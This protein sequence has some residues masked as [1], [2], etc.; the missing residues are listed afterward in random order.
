MHVRP[1]PEIDPADLDGW[2]THRWRAYTRHIGRL[3]EIPVRHEPWPLQ[4]ATVTVINES[5]TAAAGLPAPAAA[6]LAHHSAGIA[7]VAFGA[8]RPTQR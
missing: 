8:P 6:A 4:T 3:L 5:L 7:G 2:L 1:G